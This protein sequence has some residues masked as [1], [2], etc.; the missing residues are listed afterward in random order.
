[1]SFHFHFEQATNPRERRTLLLLHGTGGTEHDLVNIGKDLLPGA[2]ILSPKGKVVEQGMSRW[3]R[4]FEEGVFDE[5]DMK[6]Q[7]ND[8]ALFLKGRAESK[9]N[10]IAL[11]YSNGANMGA[12]LLTFHPEILN[13][14]IMWRGMKILREPTTSDLSKKAVLMMNGITD[15]MGPI[16]SARAQAEVFRLCGANVTMHEL[17]TGHGLTQAD[18]TLTKEWLKGRSSFA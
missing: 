15:Q 8:L 5:D 18:L 6:A 4:R 16:E 9:E 17:S 12:A 7:A 10:L 13:E 3:F 14:L 1:M 11:G 2:A